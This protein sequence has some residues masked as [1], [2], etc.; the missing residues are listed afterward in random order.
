MRIYI[1]FNGHSLCSSSPPGGRKFS[2]C[3]KTLCGAIWWAF[4]VQNKHY[5]YASG[6]IERPINGQCSRIHY[7]NSAVLTELNNKTRQLT[8]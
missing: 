8:K 6:L 5:N 4:N 2:Y 1:L 3:N 7:R